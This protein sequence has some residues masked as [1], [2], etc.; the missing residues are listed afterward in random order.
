[1]NDMIKRGML[2]IINLYVKSMG[3]ESPTDV[4]R[5]MQLHG[6]VLDHITGFQL[7]TD[8]ILYFG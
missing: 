6:Q 5:K 1:M 2:W 8:G 7:K 3:S 4:V